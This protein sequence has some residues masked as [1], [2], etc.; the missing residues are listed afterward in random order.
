MTWR[1]WGRGFKGIE[2][3]ATDSA[4]FGTDNNP[5]LLTS[6]P[7]PR[8]GIHPRSP[9]AQ[10]PRMP[11][12]PPHSPCQPIPPRPVKFYVDLGCMIVIVGLIFLYLLLGPISDLLR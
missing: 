10:T 5:L 9:S 3:L 7:V 12:F 4:L 1:E 6:R 11:S 2:D 8:Y